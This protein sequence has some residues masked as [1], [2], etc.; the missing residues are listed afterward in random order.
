M[1]EVVRLYRKGV[2]KPIDFITT[3][4]IS[5]LQQAM[6][7][8]S[9]GTHVGKI[10]VT[11]DN[12]ESKIKV[13]PAVPRATFD[14]KATY[15]LV[16][17][18]VGVGN[19]MS[20]WMIDR[21]A[22]SLAYLSRSGPNV[23]DAKDLIK[24]MADRNVEAVVLKCDVTI[25]SEVEAAIGEISNQR[26][27]KGVIHAA[28]VFEDVSFEAL[29]YI[30][31][32]KVLG[33][34]VSGT[35]NLH[36]ATLD[37]PLDF[38]TMTSSIVSV[39]GTATQASYS[40]ANSF[41]DAFARFRLSQGLPAQSLALGMILNVGFASSREE[42]QR[43]LTRNGV[44]GTSE[45]DLI[46][47]LDSAFTVQPNSSKDPFDHLAGAHLLAGLEPRKIYE[48]DRKGVGADFAWSS[49]PRFGRIIQAIQDHHEV[50]TSTNSAFLTAATSAPALSQLLS[51]AQKVK[52][53]STQ[54]LE[55]VQKL[56]N[57]ASGAVAERL[58]KLLFVSPENVDVSRDMASYG[59][60]SM[61][62]AE[63]RNW[64]FKT[65]GLD[66]SFVTL[67]GKGMTIEGLS[68]KLVEKL[69]T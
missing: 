18:V 40:A 4:D 6:M 42:I 49:D 36:E 13:A 9:K 22:R 20:N 37:Q 63:L 50:T 59:I 30:Q 31:L 45:L 14:P 65:F 44:Y 12:P 2:I 8:M 69:V 21:G 32:Q 19:S 35:I 43:S 58:T 46:Q 47:L 17:C 33:P 61:I 34:K 41:Q 52:S 39:I 67:V 51:L 53:S 28:A 7:Y 29:E 54:A 26:P 62:S 48:V 16:G 5:E 25:K 10:I 24:R 64:L 3:F 23:S 1:A 60:D 57:L 55:E 68:H 27:I 66:I 11:Y 56:R 15:V 38:F